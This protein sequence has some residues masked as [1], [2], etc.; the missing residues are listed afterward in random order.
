MEKIWTA[1]Y[2]AEKNQLEQA[3]SHYKFCFENAEKAC[4]ALGQDATL[5]V[6]QTFL[7][8]QGQVSDACGP[9]ITERMEFR[10]AA[11]AFKTM[12]DQISTA[13]ETKRIPLIAVLEVCRAILDSKVKDARPYQIFKHKNWRKML[14]ETNGFWSPSR[15]SNILVKTKP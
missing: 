5:C 3:A 12:N 8:I 11:Q 1:A 14:R 6:F 10:E 13:S 2:T 4:I 15:G 9:E 7:S